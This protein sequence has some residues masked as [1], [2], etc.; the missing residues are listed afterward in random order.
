MIRH[1]ETLMLARTESTHDELSNIEKHFDKTLSQAKGTLST[2]DNWG[3]FQ[4]AYPIKKNSYGIYLLL[5]YQIP[6]ESAT[7]VLADL[8]S[9]IKI[10]CNEL[11]LRHVT[12]KLDPKAASSYQKPESIESSKA[13]NID[14]FIKESKIEHF[15][16]SVGSSESKEENNDES[17]WND[18]TEK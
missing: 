17:S 12:L 13:G 11:V 3:K 10:K 15:L 6:Q 5:R 8:D 1:Y 14:S 7:Q 2:V 4:L 18:E 16:D 9:F